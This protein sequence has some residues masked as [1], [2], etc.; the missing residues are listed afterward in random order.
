MQYVGAAALKER[1]LDWFVGFA[2]PI[3][4]EISEL[5][6]FTDGNVAF[7]TMLIRASG[8]LQHAREVSRWVR[9]TTCCHRSTG[10]WRISHE[11]VSMPVN[12]ERES[13]ASHLAP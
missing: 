6:I 13:A 8:T 9:V 2:G 7:A 10:Y 12:L 4:Q 1:F 3:G 5:N 11:H